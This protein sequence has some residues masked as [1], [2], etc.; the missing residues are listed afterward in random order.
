MTQQTA[1]SNA[2]KA[3]LGYNENKSFTELVKIIDMPALQHS[4]NE[5]SC[6]GKDWKEFLN[7]NKTF[8]EIL[9][10]AG[11]QMFEK[12]YNIEKDMYCMM[13]INGNFNTPLSEAYFYVSDDG[14][15]YLVDKLDKFSESSRTEEQWN[16]VE[17]IKI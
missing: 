15:I 3:F 16:V 10:E 1:S 12:G 11:N 4:K 14:C 7:D 5:F 6:E 8:K 13:N 17:W 2:A 9:V